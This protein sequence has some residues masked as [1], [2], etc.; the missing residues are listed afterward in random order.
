MRKQPRTNGM[1]RSP[2]WPKSTLPSA[3]ATLLLLTCA[4]TLAGCANPTLT[5]PSAAATVSASAR[6]NGQ[7]ISLRPFSCNE[8]KLVVPH[9]GKVTPPPVEAPDISKE[10]VMARLALPDWLPQ[11]HHLFG[12]TD[13][14]IAA[15]KVNNAAWHSLCD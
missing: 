10:D 1:G 14:T 11:L 13:E 9:L 8:F 5:P 3:R 7:P 12:D 6:Q 4:M 15:A 2:A